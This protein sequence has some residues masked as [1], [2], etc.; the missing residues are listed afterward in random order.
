ME[1]DYS[2]THSL[3]FQKSI[4]EYRAYSLRHQDQALKTNGTELDTS[5]WKYF[6]LAGKGGIFEL[7]RRLRC[8]IYRG[9]KIRRWIY[10]M[11]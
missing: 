6:K 3:E 1:T 4:N 9:K 2:D 8:R 10:G 5:D 11:G 7:E